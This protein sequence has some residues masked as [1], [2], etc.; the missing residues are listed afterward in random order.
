M[1]RYLSKPTEIEAIRW[2]GGNYTDL[3][4]FM[5]DSAAVCSDKIRL[6]ATAPDEHGLLEL[7]AG[8]DGA[9]E[10]VPVPV[11]HWLVHLPGDLSDVWPIDDD[12]FQAKYEPLP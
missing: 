2:T 9:Q 3:C 5:T 12:F 7:L 4:E 8:K 1:T 6:H 10:W 11:G